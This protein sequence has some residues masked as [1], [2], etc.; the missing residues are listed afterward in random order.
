MLLADQVITNSVQTQ[1]AKA[2]IHSTESFSPIVQFKIGGKETNFGKLP[3]NINTAFY[4]LG[5]GSASM[6]LA[7]G[8]YLM[9][10]IKKDNRALQTAKQ[11]SEA[12]IAMGLTTQVFKYASGRENPSDATAARGKW[13][14][15]PGWN[16][17]Q[18]NKTQYDAFPSGHLATFVSTVTIIGQNYPELKWIK[19]VGYSISGLIG[20][21]MINNGV[22]WASDFPLGVA[23]G[24]GFGRFISRKSRFTFVN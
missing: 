16:N 3:H 2:G 14:P 7:G 18:N 24:Y 10:K 11:L 23:L 20:L 6:M 5:Q 21:S 13:R 17:F 4:N 12:F 1:F 15:F 22:H 19:P 9:G 8:F